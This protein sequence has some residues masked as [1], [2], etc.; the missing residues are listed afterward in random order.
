MSRSRISALPIVV[1]VS[2]CQVLPVFHMPGPGAVVLPAEEASP[3]LGLR[4][5]LLGIF[6]N[7]AASILLPSLSMA[8][9][10]MFGR[11]HRQNGMPARFVKFVKAAITHPIEAECSWRAGFAS[12]P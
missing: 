9:A 1:P 8:P 12:R 5:H 7:C 6:P 2:V 11:M 3:D 4:D 10:G